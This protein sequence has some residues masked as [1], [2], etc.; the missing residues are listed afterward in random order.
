MVM[1]GILI[2]FVLVGHGWC[3]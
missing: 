2:V 1:A 3:N